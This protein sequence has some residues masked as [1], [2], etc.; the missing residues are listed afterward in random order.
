MPI[1]AV[2]LKESTNFAEVPCFK[3]AAGDAKMIWS[4]ELKGEQEDGGRKFP[5]EKALGPLSPQHQLQTL[6]EYQE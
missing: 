3:K 6:I 2:D 5:P 4:K 1:Y